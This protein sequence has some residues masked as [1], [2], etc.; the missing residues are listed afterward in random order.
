MVKAEKLARSNEYG[1]KLF[2]YDGEVVYNIL[3]EEHQTMI[4][5][6]AV[7]ETLCPK[8]KNKKTNTSIE[9]RNK[10]MIPDTPIRKITGKSKL[11][12]GIRKKH[13]CLL[14]QQI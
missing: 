1:I 4:A 3:M 2:P 8:D 14:H 6:G 7:I 13:S 11:M 12:S 10:K 9:I 5:N